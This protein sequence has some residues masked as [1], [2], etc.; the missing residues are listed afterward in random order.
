LKKVID[1]HY[2]GINTFSKQNYWYM[3]FRKVEQG[4][5]KVE[6]KKVNFC[7]ETCDSRKHY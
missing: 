3:E 7:L 1:K 2:L 4:A 6:E 5:K